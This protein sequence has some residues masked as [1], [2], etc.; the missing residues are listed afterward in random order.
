MEVESTNELQ[1]ETCHTF[2]FFSNFLL[3]SAFIAVIS[4]TILLPKG[5]GIVS[6][7]WSFFTLGLPIFP[8]IAFPAIPARTSSRSCA[9]T[10]WSVI[11]KDGEEDRC[12]NSS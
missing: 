12:V 6:S 11:I 7:S 4:G 2:F 9:S 3:A 10:F 8:F 1:Q 5:E